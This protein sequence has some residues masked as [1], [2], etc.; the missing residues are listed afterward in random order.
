MR[1][2]LLDWY[3]SSKRDLP[4]RRT[5]DPYAIWIS[6]A[7][8]QQTRVETVERYWRRFIERLPDVA[9]LA[10]ASDDEV[11]GLWSG[12]GYYRRARALRA[13]ARAIVERHGGRFPSEREALLALP[14]IGPY[15]AGAIASIAFD[16]PE[17][18]VD[19]NV[20]RVL[21]R[22][23]AL[24]AEGAA[25]DRE[26]WRTA[27]EE[28]PSRGFGEW[29]QALMELGATLCTARDPACGECPV[30]RH[31]AA[32]AQGRTAELPRP[33]RRPEPI[34]VELEVLLVRRGDALLFE[35][36]PDVGRMAG[37]WQLPT[38]ELASSPRL[39]AERWPIDGALV[40]GAELG[41]VRHTITRHRIRA[42]VRAGHLASGFRIRAPLA[43]I[44]RGE[45]A[46]APLTGMSKKILAARFEPGLFADARRGKSAPVATSRSRADTALR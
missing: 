27:R 31:C 19:G 7:M 30:A 18:L 13:A 20:A 38:I 15:T 35:R 1:R 23:F 11:L 4:W 10:A 33:R 32:L 40:P 14:G 9:A 46:G 25:L 36:R 41:T 37:M 39:F 44:E 6:E 28:L 42:R 12:L 29:N 8:L 26:L 34:D 24:D 45:L 43:W 22:L 3:R 21:S 17:P 2:E 5:R 16:R